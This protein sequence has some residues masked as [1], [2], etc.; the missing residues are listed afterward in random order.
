MIWSTFTLVWVLMLVIWGITVVV[1]EGGLRE[2]QFALFLSST[3]IVHCTSLLAL[4]WALPVSRRLR[5]A[6]MLATA[7]ISVLATFLPIVSFAFP[8]QSPSE[9]LL[10]LPPIAVGLGVLPTSIWVTVAFLGIG[11]FGRLK[12]HGQQVSAA[13][14][15][16]E[17]DAEEIRAHAYRAR[18]QPD[19]VVQSL[20]E[21]S[22]RMHTAP[23]DADRLLVEFSELLRHTIRRTSVALIPLRDE[24]RYVID[25][26]RIVDDVQGSATQVHLDL[27]GDSPDIRVP[28]GSLLALLERTGV[29]LGNPLRQTDILV[30]AHREEA[31]LTLSCTLRPPGML[32][33]AVTGSDRSERSDSR[34]HSLAAH[35][36]S[37]GISINVSNTSPSR[38]WMELPLCK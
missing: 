33:Q 4:G 7:C 1:L 37:N 35:M 17:A 15:A 32:R 5:P 28:T 27:G 14:S 10:L 31:H 38:V 25:Y 21:I 3:R 19:F 8:G 23:G 29:G 9:G 36:E 34:A 24:I 30:A 2:I 20:G 11:R 26:V 16:M 13:A 12:L 18:L 6:E 22:S